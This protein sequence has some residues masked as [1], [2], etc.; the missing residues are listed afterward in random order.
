MA[1]PKQQPQQPGG[2]EIRK[3][4]QPNHG[5]GPNPVPPSGGSGLVPAPRPASDSPK[6]PAADSSKPPDK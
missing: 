3:G 1:D 6:A 5:L 2:K 4:Y